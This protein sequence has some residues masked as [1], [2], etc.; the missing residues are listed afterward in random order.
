MA[1]SDTHA[2]PGLDVTVERTGPCLA[3]VRFTVSKEETQKARARGLKNAAR[4][5]RMKGFRPGKVPPAFVEK[6]FGEEI[7]RQLVEHFVQHAFQH[8]IDDEG[9][10]PA[11]SPRIEL[12]SIEAKT[13]ADWGHEFEVLLRPEV[14]LGQVD[15]LEVESMPVGVDDEELDR[16]LSGIRGE[17]S[18]PE[19]AGD[20]GLPE[21]GMAICKL[22]F[23]LP[24]SEEP[25]LERDA[26]RL[27]PQTPPLGLDADAFK[28]AMTGCK[29]GDSREFELEFPED[30]PVEDARGKK[31]ILRVQT[32]TCFRIVP[33]TDETVFAEFGVEDEDGFREEVR[34][35][36]LAAKQNQEE[37]RIE[38]VLLEKL[39]ENHPME[40][41]EPIVAE[42]ADSKV[43][44]IRAA[45]EEQGLEGSELEARL[46]EER[47]VAFEN[48]AKAMRAIYLMEEVAREKKIEVSRDD[49]E[50]EFQAIA[51][52]NNVG[53]DQVR[54]YYQ[55]EHLLQQLALE[56]LERKVRVY[57]RENAKIQEAD[58]GS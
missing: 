17:M 57:L 14:E 40:L 31:G 25:I 58:S 27:S 53:A 26:I 11:R 55:E 37:Q 24:D 5:T 23:L 35:R 41:P 21:N 32:D 38:Q 1:N 45:L 19:P 28:E 8:A 29:D 42:Q 20:E 39:I 43:E 9:L 34:R 3:T 46:A 13:D 2:H 51:E 30:F 16:T 4:G 44:E 15:G 36:I 6:R 52:R 22:A 56:L 47:Q 33:P 7:D 18:T 48:S 49:F 10:K 54:K 50:K 12:E